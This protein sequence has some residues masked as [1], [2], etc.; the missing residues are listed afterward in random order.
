MG[1][2]SH[3]TTAGTGSSVVHMIGW[4]ASA[5]DRPGT[6]QEILIDVG[7]QIYAT[8][9]V[10]PDAVRRGSCG[11]AGRMVNTGWRDDVP[12]KWRPDGGQF[13]DKVARAV[14]VGI[15]IAK[16]DGAAG[17]APARSGRCWGGE[18]QVLVGWRCYSVRAIA[19]RSIRRREIVGEVRDEVNGTPATRLETDRRG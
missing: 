1:A 5:R 6:G 13:G 15:E 16:A 17:N 2:R 14:V 8:M 9:A 3:K 18:P 10:R 7:D 12:G 11:Q 19:W 4:P